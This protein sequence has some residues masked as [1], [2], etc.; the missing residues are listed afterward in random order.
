MK[1]IL[2]ADDALFMRMM[3]KDLLTRNGFNVV[4]E[5]ENGEE[6]VEQYRELKPDIV[7]IDILMPSLDGL[8]AM[9]QIIGEYPSA[10]VVMISAMGQKAYVERAIE[11]GAKDFITKPFSPPKVIEI[12]QNIVEN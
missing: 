4:G 6:V 9:E 1:R 3:L 2:I 7:L 8:S 12:L 11:L 10:R 5:A